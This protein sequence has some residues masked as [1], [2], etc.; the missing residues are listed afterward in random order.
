MLRK[1]T[2]LLLTLLLVTAA[3]GDDG[4]GSPGFFDYIVFQGEAPP[5][6][7]QMQRAP[8][9][10]V[11][12]YAS[13]QAWLDGEAPL[14]TYTANSQ[15]EVFR[16]SEASDKFPNGAVVYA[17]LEAANNW[18]V[19]LSQPLE[20]HDP[21]MP[22]YKSGSATLY[23]TFMNDFLN[24]ASKSFLLTDL[25]VNN[26]SIFESVADCS[27]DNFL[28]LK[29]DGNLFYSEGANVCAGK[30][31]TANYEIIIPQSKINAPI[32]T[33]NSTVLYDFGVIWADVNNKIYIKQ[34]F[35][36]I[37]FKTNEGINE[38][39]SIYTRQD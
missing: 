2:Y 36:Q 31:A 1:S 35:T 4:E 21:G 3:C 5:I 10:T 6:N 17:E 27:K 18:P 37:W 28:R 19:F 9:A 30:T 20:E 12:V 11:K 29:K 33:L 25:R 34:D 39:I 7:N 15:G 38:Y 8:N 32:I 13:A 23:N 14:K 22:D 26:V 24:A 16:Q